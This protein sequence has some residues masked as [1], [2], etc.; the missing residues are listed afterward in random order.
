MARILVVDDDAVDRMLL[1]SLLT[2]AGHELVI[3]DSGK[4]ALALYKR[5]KFDLVVT[6]LVMNEIDGLSLIRKIRKQDPTAIVAITG[7]TPWDLPLAKDSGAVGTVTK[8][9]DRE[10]L[11]GTIDEALGPGRERRKKGE[12]RK[13]RERRG[14]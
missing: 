7:L 6:D 3:T 14:N 11:L 2:A 1:D 10:V 4:S 13:G 12:R 9:I 5:Q 8:P